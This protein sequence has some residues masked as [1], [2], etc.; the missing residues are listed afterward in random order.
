[1]YGG[2]HEVSSLCKGGMTSEMYALVE[3]QKD[4][5]NLQCLYYKNVFHHYK[6]MCV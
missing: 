1:V 3:R 2:K 5:L 4:I 6:H